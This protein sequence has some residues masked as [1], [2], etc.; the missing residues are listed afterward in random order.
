MSAEEVALLMNAPVPVD[1]RMVPRAGHFSFMHTLP[2]G[3]AE[4]NEFDR[5]A[6]L[7]RISEETLQFLNG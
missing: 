5:V 6:A 1:M 4:N 3:V 2:P 7:T